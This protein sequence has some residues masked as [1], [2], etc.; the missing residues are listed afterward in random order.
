MGTH[1][2]EA[3]KL[4]DQ[5]QELIR[6]YSHSGRPVDDLPYTAEFEQIC[7]DVYG[8]A[9]Q[10][11]L[12]T[13]FHRLL[14]LRKARRLPRIGRIFAE[15]AP[16]NIEEHDILSDLIAR[17]AGTVGHR[18]S[19]P[20]T[21]EFDSVAEAFNQQTGRNLDPHTVWRMIARVAKWPVPR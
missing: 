7:R 18:D 4:S 10:Q 8:N 3:P 5:D 9:S 1:F 14:N 15:R 2:K 6:R 16:L 12:R 19:L 20:F 13:A 21:P 17:S 11:T